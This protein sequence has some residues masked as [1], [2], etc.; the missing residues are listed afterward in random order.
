[1]AAIKEE[2]VENIASIEKSAGRQKLAKIL[3]LKEYNEENDLKAAIYVDYLYDNV[4]FAAEKGFSWHQVTVILQFALDFLQQCQGKPLSSAI[5]CFKDLSGNLAQVLGERNYK[6]YTDYVFSTFMTHY[7]LF[8]YVFTQDRQTNVPHVSLA[9]NVPIPPEELTTSKPD[10][11]WQYEKKIEGLDDLEMTKISER[12]QVKEKLM[13]EDEGQ[14][15]AVQEKIFSSD[16]PLTKESLGEMIRDVMQAY[17]TSTAASLKTTVQEVGEDLNL[18]L[19]KTSLPRPQALGPPP[20]Y[21]LRTPITATAAGKSR[22][23]KS[24]DSDRSSRKSLKSAK[25]KT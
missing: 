10:H 16:L 20:R 2:E 13:M 25:T 9:V 1:M 5:R 23:N 12:I 3:K 24:H 17:T 11:I 7:Q 18:M 4:M 21:K 22:Q 14:Q 15:L 19:E 8:T 6:Q